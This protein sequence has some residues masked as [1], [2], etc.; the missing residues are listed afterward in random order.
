LFRGAK[1]FVFRFIKLRKVEGLAVAK[2]FNT[3]TDWKKLACGVTSSAK[4]AKI[5]II[6]A[7]TFSCGT[8]LFF[9]VDICN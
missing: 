4:Q 1:Y 3:K 2:P 5:K 6:T 9:I 8:G 7:S